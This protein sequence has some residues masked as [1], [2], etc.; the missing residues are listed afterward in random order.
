MSRQPLGWHAVYAVYRLCGH[1]RLWAAWGAWAYLC[2]QKTSNEHAH[3]ANCDV[4]IAS[5]AFRTRII[6][7]NHK[8]THATNHSQIL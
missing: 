8:I 6:G 2:H 4:P 1:G 5:G 7:E 3:L